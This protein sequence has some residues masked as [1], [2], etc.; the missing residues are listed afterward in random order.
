VRGAGGLTLRSRSVLMRKM[1]ERG[2]LSFKVVR[3][4]KAG[5]G[6]LARASNILVSRAAFDV[7]VSLFGPA[8]IELRQASRVSSARR[9]QSRS[10]TNVLGIFCCLCELL[11]T[12]R[13][14][15]MFD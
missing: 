15:R 12:M 13:N 4:E 5:P 7:A 6:V 10:A 2:Q 8:H 14:R 11:H 1:A 9:V 3:L